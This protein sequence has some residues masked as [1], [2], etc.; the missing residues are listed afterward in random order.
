MSDHKFKIGQTM[1]FNPHRL[2]TRTR[3]TRC[4]ITRLVTSEGGGP[5]YHI[6]CDAEA[7]ER[8]VWE[9]ELG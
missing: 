1:H 5:R 2:N 6:K 7:F 4:K 3:A 8:V 9:S